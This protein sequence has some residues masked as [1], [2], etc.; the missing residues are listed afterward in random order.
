MNDVQVRLA[1]PEF[2]YELA[3][4][5]R[6]TNPP[7]PIYI[8]GGAVRDAYLRLPT[9][10]V[11]FAVGGDALALAREV[12]DRLDGDIYVMDRER[13]VSRV[14][15]TLDG[16]ALRLDFARFRGAT[17]DDDLRDRDFTVNAMAAD[18]LGE[19]DALIDPLG[20][21]VDLQRRVL[22]RCSP[23]SIEADP[24]RVLRSVRLG[25]QFDLKL[26]PATAA[27]IRRRVTGLSQ[28]SRE[29]IRDEFFKLLS[30][31]RAARGLRVLKH[32]SAMEGILPAI[33]ARDG[34]TLE[35]AGGQNAWAQTFA[36]VDRLRAILTAIS[37][38]RTDNTAAAFD[39]G[40]LVIQLDRHRRQ[41]QAHLSQEYGNGRRRSELLTLA[42]LLHLNA[43]S[44]G[45]QISAEAADRLRLSGEER[46]TLG[47]MIGNCSQIVER[48][49]WTTLEQHRFWFG[50]GAGGIDVILLGAAHVLGRAGSGLEQ[51]AWLRLVE[52]ATDLLDIWFERH[53]ELVS[54]Q[55]LLDGNDIRRLLEIRPSPLIGRLLTALREEQ[56]TGGVKTWDEACD[57]VRREAA[58]SRL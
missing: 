3:E 21:A 33:A 55:L 36:V 38:R 44:A 51:G 19:I 15:L 54:P 52:R 20:G 29:R 5:L 2:V 24:L 40:M 18:A 31:D 4:L 30:L 42:A 11:D 50:L 46:R 25:A 28:V 49:C 22:R 53:D 14:F 6:A 10:D 57:F 9:T 1:W 35:S 8:V 47:M 43:A 56:V 7:A 45:A 23:R 13:D 32:L 48:D 27:D 34:V 37:S 26:E 41:L 58:A 17:L 16:Q 12:A 39:L